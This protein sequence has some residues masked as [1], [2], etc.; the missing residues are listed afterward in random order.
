VAAI[1]SQLTG[2]CDVGDGSAMSVFTKGKCAK[3]GGSGHQ[4][5]DCPS[6][7]HGFDA[8]ANS[9]RDNGT[10]AKQ[11]N[12]DRRIEYR[13]DPGSAAPPAQQDSNRKKRGTKRESAKG[14]GSLRRH[15][16]TQD[17]RSGELD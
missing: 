4:H 12:V 5:K 7:D 3:C 14:V 9:K 15:G 11:K 1:F 10:S 2:N 13:H 6:I 8:K 17:L 16:Q